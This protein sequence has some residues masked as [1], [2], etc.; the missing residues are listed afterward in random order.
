MKKTINILTGAVVTTAMLFT[1]IQNA[2][3][4][5]LPATALPTTAK[6]QYS[7]QP[8]KETTG[9][10]VDGLTYVRGRDLADICYFSFLWDNQDKKAVII[11]PLGQSVSYTNDELANKGAYQYKGENYFQVRSLVSQG[12]VYPTIDYD[13]KSKTIKITEEL[14]KNDSQAEL[15]SYVKTQEQYNEDKLVGQLEE[16]RQE[17]E[18]KQEVARNTPVYIKDLDYLSKSAMDFW[19]DDYRDNLGNQYSYGGLYSTY[20]SGEITYYLNGKYNKLQ[21]T[22]V[23]SS[24]DKNTSKSQEV[25]IYGDEKLLYTSPIITKN[26]L[27]EKFEINVSGVQKLTIK[28]NGD[29]IDIGIVDLALYK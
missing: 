3:A 14:R 7:N 6:I 19:K 10:V 27:P 1:S 2:D 25:Y 22:F 18:Q 11:N 24:R 9:F 23:L 16:I 4:K 26:F 12:N 28:V 5:P 15:Q 17:Q 20:Y 29:D 21:G 13:T 8:V